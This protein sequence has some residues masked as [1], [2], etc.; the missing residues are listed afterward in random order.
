MNSSPYTTRQ[1]LFCLVSALFTVSAVQGVWLIL[2]DS[3]TPGTGIMAQLNAL[4]DGL[5]QSFC[6]SWAGWAALLVFFFLAC[7]RLYLDGEPFR[8][9]FSPVFLGFCFTLFFMLGASMEK[10]SALAPVLSGRLQLALLAAA[11][12]GCFLPL[13]AFFYRLPVWLPRVLSLRWAPAEKLSRRIQARRPLLGPMAFFCLCW[14]PVWI[15]AFPGGL[16][17]DT[18]TQLG[19]LQPENIFNNHYPYL[20]TLFYAGV[21]QVGK[22]LGQP[23]LALL[24]LTAVQYFWQAYALAYCMRTLKRL[25]ASGTLRG[26]FLVLFGLVTIWPIYAVCVQKDTLYNG[27]VVVLLCI[28]A[29]LIYTPRLLTPQ[30]TGALLGLFL[31]VLHTRNN[32]LYLCVPL[33]AALGAALGR[34]YLVRTGAVLVLGLGIYA[35]TQGPLMTA[36]HCYGGETQ[37]MLSIP[38]QQTARYVQQYAD[39]LTDEEILAID[40]VLVYDTLAQRYNP[41]ISDPVKMPYRLRYSTDKAHE[42][43]LLQAY[44]A[45][46]AQEFT[47]HPLVYLEAAAN[48]M[49]GFVA[50]ISYRVMGPVELNIDIDPALDHSI[51]DYTQPELLSPVRTLYAKTSTFVGK[52]PFVSLLYQPCVSLWTVCV[53]AVLL[54]RCKCW[55]GMVLYLPMLVN[56]AVCL[57][58]PVNASTRYMLCTTA[59]VPLLLTVFLKEKNSHSL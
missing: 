23:W 24:F 21:S 55:R 15:I 16:A 12:L 13:T 38:F 14:L 22:S 34:R 53:G 7:R 18:G 28:A 32:G 33:L 52:L 8:I 26:I 50:P 1:N 47:K 27:G 29:E 17:S 45:V 19:M 10:Y 2:P 3:G 54:L 40:D 56:A 30:T 9:K 6:Q 49:Y 58:G 41:Y 11:A 31:L 46:W 39:E 25:G 37:E 59:L 36:I 35:V 48:N 43:E 44:F 51:V 42:R 20:T 5:N 57:V 4:L